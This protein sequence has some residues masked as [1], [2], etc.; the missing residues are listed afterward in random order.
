M[1]SYSCG[2]EETTGASC[3]HFVQELERHIG[4]V[5]E[6]KRKFREKL[7]QLV[8]KLRDRWIADADAPTVG[9]QPG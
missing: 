6:S 4:R 8:K 9:A 7:L 1:L 2:L 5:G 3:A